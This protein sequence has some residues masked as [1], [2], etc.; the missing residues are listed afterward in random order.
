MPHARLAA[1]SAQ[2]NPALTLLLAQ[3][4]GGDA[5]A[6]EAV[7]AAVY[8]PLKQLARARLRGGGREAFQTTELVHDA[9]L[10]LA[11]NQVL[12]PNDR[13]HLMGLA[14]TAMRQ[15][16]IDHMRQRQTEKHGGQWQR[17]TLTDCLAS[18]D[19]AEIE[20]LRLDELL[21]SLRLLDPRAARMVELRYFGGYDENEIADLLEVSVRTVRRDWR[22]TRAWLKTELEQ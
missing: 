7:L 3:A 16:L 2:E 14:A 18:D 21:R 8:G 10:K 9:W 13:R 17:M 1:M 15:I 6:G 22:R 5:A 20:V 12:A 4:R 19:A 11:G